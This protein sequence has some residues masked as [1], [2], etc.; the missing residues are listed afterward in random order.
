MHLLNYYRLLALTALVPYC[1]PQI[2]HP[3]LPY[4]V[5]I[6]SQKYPSDRSK[7]P[8][9]CH[10]QPDEVLTVS[11][12]LLQLKEAYFGYHGYWR[13]LSSHKI[14][15]SHV[16][17]GYELRMCSCQE[18]TK[19]T[20]VRARASCSEEIKLQWL[21]HFRQKF[22]SIPTASPIHSNSFP[23]QCE[24]VLIL[25]VDVQTVRHVFINS[26]LFINADIKVPKRDKS[27]WLHKG[28]AYV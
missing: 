16:R 17:G 8:D 24:G 20:L 10:S 4:A 12:Q 1:R 25:S 15:A 3:R 13:D 18:W 6:H 28:H 14:L 7:R 9:C 23:N 11:R 19:R 27:L 5:P 21:R 22:H 2:Y 26:A